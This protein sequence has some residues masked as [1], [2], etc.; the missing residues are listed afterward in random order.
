M[1]NLI[2]EFQSREGSAM[3]TARTLAFINPGTG[4]QFG[5]LR[6]TTPQEVD[7]A[8]VEL[9]A[10][11]KPWGDMPVQDRVKVLRKLQKVMIDSLDEITDVL[12]QNCGKSRQDSL[13]EAFVTIDMLEQYCKRAPRWLS[14]RRVSQGLYLT[15]RCY[16]EYRPYGVVGVIAPWN[17]PFALSMP[18]ALAALL[19]G[20][21]VILKPSEVTPATGVLIDKLFKRVPEL[22]PYVRV[23]HGDGVVGE[24]LVRSSPD[25]IFLTGS[26]ST[27]RKVLQTAAE[28][29]LPVACELGGKDAMVVLEDADLAAAAHW[30]AWGA[31][32]NSGQTCMAVE[33]VYVV[34][35][36][37]D[38]FV[39]LAVEETRKLEMGYS[40]DYEC[41]YYFGPITDPRQLKIISRHLEDAKVKGA[42]L[43]IG[44]EVQD[45]FIAPT[46]LV[47]VD[48]SMLVMREETFGPLMPVMKVR[49][50]EEAIRMAND[51]SL[52]LG[53]SVWSSDLGRAQRVA[54]RI[55]AAS[56]VINDTISQFAVPMLP[57]GGI[58]ESGYGR[59]HGKEGMMQFTRPYS[60]AVGNPP[61]EWD[62]ATQMRKPG[63]YKLGATLIHVLFGVTPGQ[64]L[65]P[66]TEEIRRKVSPSD[67][68]MLASGLGIMGMVG[69]AAGLAAIW[70]GRQKK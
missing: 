28:K 23:I 11:Q 59:I 43:L 29:L 49:D 69:A 41:P 51:C 38:E 52:G 56:I 54:R 61:I 58:K 30:G 6:M 45:M 57:F 63:N 10:A 64:R 40:R 35:A 42:R 34:E 22:A 39:R 25:Y 24:A 1:Y 17:Y 44:G 12:N 31:F 3:E 53:A 55:E 8:V 5:E 33:R 37:Y 7:Q 13:I 18:P 48:H 26:V 66:V 50:E 20:N 21:T 16:V 15:K 9:R 2:S 19:A 27:G 36:V 60:Y 46:V 70:I 32:F 47:N 65:Q 68:K 4:K 14:R 67:R 62:I